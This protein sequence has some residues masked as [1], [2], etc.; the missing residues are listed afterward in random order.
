[1]CPLSL[2]AKF[3]EVKKRLKAM[4]SVLVAYSGGADSTLLLKI[5]R[6]VLGDNVL[7]VT[8]SSET[9]TKNEL[10][11]AKKTARSLR[12]GHKVIR[13]KE[14][15][16]PGFRKNFEDRC[17]YCKKELFSRLKQI[18][19]KKGLRFVADGSNV[20]D[21]G[22]Y[23]PGARA[24]KEYGVVSPLQEAGMTKKDVRDLSGR[25]RLVTWDKPALAC[26]ASRI[27]YRSVITRR[28]LLRIE[29]AEMALRD[30]FDIRGN[31]R[32]RDFGDCCRI[33]VDKKEIKKIDPASM[34]KIFKAVGY[35]TTVIDPKGY[36]MGSMNE[37]VIPMK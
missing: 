30:K 29:E 7:A 13:T 32:V 33:E 20:D 18:A 10:A 5:A 37:T 14:L 23:R 17:Y 4:G 34:L 25:L 19:G 24:K 16:D 35:E 21:L 6:D 12:A 27:Q 2:D 9:Y 31:L 26:L 22:D 3:S 15:L 1:M 36:R 11:F 8:A 28:R